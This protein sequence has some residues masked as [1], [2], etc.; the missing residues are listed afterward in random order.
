MSLQTDTLGDPVAVLRRAYA[1]MGFG[2]RDDALL[3]LF[4]QDEP[5][6]DGRLEPRRG[7]VLWQVVDL[8]GGGRYDSRTLAADDLFGAIPGHWQVT[9][10]ETA[11][12]RRH[13][14][15]VVV[16]GRIFC[17]PPRSYDQ[18]G[19]PFA[20]IWTFVHGRVAQVRSYLEGIELRRLERAE[21]GPGA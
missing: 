19:L 14:D 7:P 21:P 20:H 18:M 1:A 8:V 3:E 15:V 9:R 4:G 12:L 2:R 5:R 13:G 11:D 6:V 16:T 10:V 17:R